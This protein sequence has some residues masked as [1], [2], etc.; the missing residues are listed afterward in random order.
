MQKI[1]VTSFLAFSLSLLNTSA[2]HAF[3]V[4]SLSEGFGTVSTLAANGWALPNYSD[5]PPLVTSTTWAQGSTAQSTFTGQDGVANAYIQADLPITNGDITGANGAVSAWII[6]PELDFTNG[7]TVSFYA[8]T[9]STQTK[10]E[11]LEVRQSN[12]GTSTGFT[13]ANPGANALGNFTTLV[14]SAGNLLG[15]ADAEPTDI[16]FTVWRQYTFNVAPGSNGSIA[17]RYVAT[18]GGFNGTQAGYIGVDTV[19]YTA[20]PEPVSSSLAGF[21]ALG[22]VSYMK[23]KRK[24]SVV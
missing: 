23:G 9:L 1:A 21:A 3:A 14:G 8:R 4:T 22:L 11:F 2:V 20:A 17:F 15:P 10:A 5:P 6:T 7:G 18:D 19:Q 24:R 16:P 12:A 13:S